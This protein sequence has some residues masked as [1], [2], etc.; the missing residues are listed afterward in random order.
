MYVWFVFSILAHYCSSCPFFVSGVRAGVRHYGLEFFTRALPCL[1][2][3]YSL[4]YI[5]S[6]KVIPHNIYELLTPAALAHL[7]MGD[8]TALPQ[9]LILCTN[10]FSLPDIVRLMNVLMI[11][12]SLECTNHIKRRPSQKIEHLIYIKERSMPH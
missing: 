11:R 2:E 4:F 1:T 12:Y 6:K 7:I 3:I 10:S 5:D 8:G 9:G